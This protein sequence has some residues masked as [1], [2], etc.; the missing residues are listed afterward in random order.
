[1]TASPPDRPG[2][3]EYAPFYSR[4][5]ERVPDGDIRRIL[6]G[7]IGGTMG[8]VRGHADRA[9]H[10]YAEG[11][12]SVREVIG[13]L[14]DTERVL[15]WR[16]LAIARGEVASLPGFDE[17]AYA[18]VSNAGDRPLDD[19]LDE[20]AAVRRATV[21][22]AD[23]LAPDAW[24]R[25]GTANGL[26]VSVRALAWIIAGHELHHRAILEDRYGLRA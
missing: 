1:M 4:Y 14:S 21:Y 18:A 9:G 8:P 11:K 6:D 16:M 3:D 20:L 5:V 26:P 12:W 7:Q 24:T 2:P 13:H 15:S 17:N 22:L 23:S 19:L 10:R 25:R